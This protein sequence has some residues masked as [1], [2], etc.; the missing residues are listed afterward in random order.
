MRE[1]FIQSFD[2]HDFQRAFIEYF[3][4]LGIKLEDYSGLFGE[5]NS[6]PNGKNY[7]YVSLSERGQ[8]CGF[9]QF[10]EIESKSWFFAEQLGFIREFWVSDKCRGRGVGT[11]L[12]SL[13]ES[14]FKDRGIQKAI[15]T[16][17]TAE[18]F[19]LKRGYTKESGITA[20]NGDEVFTKRL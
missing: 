1:I 3:T 10:I 8:V 2:N 19:Y 15:L 4:E 18:G 5:M 9:I 13:A 16:T 14:Y 20:R 17:D 11:R 7:A 12:I 6:D